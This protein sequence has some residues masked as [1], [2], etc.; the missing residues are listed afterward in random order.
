MGHIK[1]ISATELQEL[2]RRHP[3]TILV[4][5]RN[6]FEHVTAGAIPGVVPIPLDELAS[7]MGELPADRSHP[8]VLVCQSGGRSLTAARMLASHGY[9]EAYSLDGGTGGWL[10]AYGA[11]STAE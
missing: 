2:R 8:I 3:D 9:T 10:R 6:P 7:R 1:R 11:R 4:D 5:V